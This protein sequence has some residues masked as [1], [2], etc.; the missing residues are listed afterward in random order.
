M[1]EKKIGREQVLEA[2]RIL[3]KYKQD[4]FLVEGPERDKR[5]EIS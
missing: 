5:T 1:K 4:G 2:S 3:K